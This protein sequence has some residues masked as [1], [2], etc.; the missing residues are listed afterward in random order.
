MEPTVR[1][2]AILLWHPGHVAEAGLFRR[3][4]KGG[5][6]HSGPE[7][8]ASVAI[9]AFMGSAEGMA[10]FSSVLSR[11]VCKDPYTTMAMSLHR[12]PPSSSEES[13]EA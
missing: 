3:A 11:Y 10:L 9:D 1:A 2:R 13:A 6:E 4:R 8:E 12:R 5:D 7:A